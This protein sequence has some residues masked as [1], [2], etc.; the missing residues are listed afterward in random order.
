M[1]ARSFATWCAAAMHSS[2]YAG[3]V[4]IERIRRKW[5]NRARLASRSA[6][7]RAR[8]AERMSDG[9]V[10]RLLNRSEPR[11]RLRWRSDLNIDSAYRI[12]SSPI[13]PLFTAV[14]AGLSQRHA[15]P[16]IDPTL[17]FRCLVM[18]IMPHPI[19]TFASSS[20]GS[21]ANVRIER[22]LAKYRFPVELWI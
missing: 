10:L 14:S 2:L 15:A 3:S 7:I 17:V 6:S 16:Q 8:T 11:A 21:S 20:D 4:E 9:I 1:P 19:L 13:P 12:Q 5:N 18:F 22:L